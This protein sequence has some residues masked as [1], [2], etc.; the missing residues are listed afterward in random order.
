MFYSKKLNK[1]KSIKHCFFSR[2]GGFSK[3]RFYKSLNCGKGSKDS[4]KNISKNLNYVSKKM[5]VKK[6]KLILMNQTHSARVIEIKKNNYTKK[7]HSDAIITKVKGLALGVVTA[8]CVPI[9]MYDLKN[10]I[11]GCIHAG[12]KGAFSGIIKNT[13]N[14]IK[15][16]NSN[17]N[18][19]ASI[20]PCIGEKNYEVDLNFYKKFYNKSYK[21]KKYFSYK[22][23]NKKL[24]NLR[25]FVA[26][27][28]IELKVKVDHV[29]R[30]TFSEKSN[31]FSYRRSCKLKENDYG[32]C[33]SIIRII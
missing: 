6:N 29:D 5:F 12:W 33:I 10:E 8:D 28:L 19:Y 13:V 1:F 32:R 27:K 4:K 17:N 15:K 11:I 3:G 25:K 2:K 9:I 7:I 23:K 30:D 31:F 21:N 16:L 18:I 22:N 20:G 14:K 26:D 24:F